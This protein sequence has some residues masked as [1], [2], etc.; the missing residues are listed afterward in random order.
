MKDNN[1]LNYLCIPSSG[2]VQGKRVVFPYS[3]LKTTQEEMLT[4]AT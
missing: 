3:A 2:W 4:K 1:M